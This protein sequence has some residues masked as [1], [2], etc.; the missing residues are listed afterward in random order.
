MIRGAR[1]PFNHAKKETETYYYIYFKPDSKYLAFRLSMKV[2]GETNKQYWYGCF[3]GHRSV[4]QAMGALLRLLWLAEYNVK[5]PA[6]LPVQ[7]NRN[8]TPMHYCM[9]WNCPG[10]PALSQA[11]PGMLE[12]WLRAESPELLDWF[13]VNIETEQRLNTFQNCYLETHLDVLKT[14]YDKKLVQHRDIRGDKSIIAQDEIDDL[15]VGKQRG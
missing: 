9:R 6:Y 13:W 8:L 12:K 5:N 1:P 7:L 10:S 11:V 14:F 3:K 4:R 2:P 15:L